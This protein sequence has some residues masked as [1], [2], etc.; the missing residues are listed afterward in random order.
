MTKRTGVAVMLVVL[1]G[2]TGSGRQADSSPASPTIRTPPATHT[3]TSAAETH[4]SGHAAKE[5]D[6][7]G[8]RVDWVVYA[9]H[10]HAVAGWDI[11]PTDATVTGPCARL[12]TQTADGWATSVVKR[13]L[14]VPTG[15]VTSN[16][17][18]ALWFGPKALEILD[19]AG[20]ARSVP[21]SLRPRPAGPGATIFGSGWSHVGVETDLWA[22]HRLLG[23]ANPL[24]PTPHITTRFSAAL[25][26]DGRLWVEGWGS[27]QQVWVAWT[28]DGGDTWTEHLVTRSG[29]PGGVTVGSGGQVAA[30]AWVAPNDTP[31]SASVITYDNGATWKP[32][33]RS[34][35]PQWVSSEGIV[36]GSSG[37]ATMPDG[38]IFVADHSTH[39]LWT[40]K[41]DWQ[42]FRQVPE[43]G[44]VDWVQTNGSLLWAGHDARG[45]R[46]VV[47]A[48]AGHS[49][50]Y[51]T[52]G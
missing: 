15:S 47:S 26:P 45:K 44:S 27:K 43:V 23:R 46:I 42:E 36:G 32:Y 2:C 1:A 10:D 25:A 38:T 52:P 5:L 30:F 50:Q 4:G 12:W 24:P 31:R 7:P 22:Y 8:A 19:A 35:G 29:Y 14:N 18:V 20:R 11:C 3:P 6:S 16:G 28:D 9:G 37:V 49:W 21:T 13:P 33:S 39:A 40:S 41:G 17:S 51:V 48:D 34:D